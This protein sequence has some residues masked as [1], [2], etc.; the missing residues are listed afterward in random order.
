MSSKTSVLRSAAGSSGSGGVIALDPN[1]TH[2]GNMSV[3]GNMA[4]RS[5][6]MLSD[7]TTKSH[8]EEVPA[9][10]CMSSLNVPLKSW[11]WNSGPDT[12]THVGFISQDVRNIGDLSVYEIVQRKEVD[13]SSKLYLK[14]EEFNFLRTEALK[15]K[16]EELETGLLSAQRRIADLEEALEE[17]EELLEEVECLIQQLKRPNCLKRFC[18]WLW[19]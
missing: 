11:R 10:V 18:Q 17:R 4:C 1:Y 13:G 16:A 2:H 12:S 19:S 9:H 15:L 3:L 5:F 14:T 8:V 7:G 6:S